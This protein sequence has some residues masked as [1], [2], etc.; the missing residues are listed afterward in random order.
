MHTADGI[1]SILKN[2]PKLEIVD[3]GWNKH[4]EEVEMVDLLKM[5]PK[6]VHTL[7][8]SGNSQCADDTFDQISQLTWLQTL[9]L[10]WNK[11]LT[12]KWLKH[13]LKG[14]KQI[15]KLDVG[16]FI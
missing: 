13:I 8:L 1:A 7:K 4:I 5:I 3:I 6:T 16:V 11:Q 14:C 2:C 15:T 12:H 9:N 10:R